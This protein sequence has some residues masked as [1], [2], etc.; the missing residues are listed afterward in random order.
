MGVPFLP[1]AGSTA[2][3]WSA[4]ADAVPRYGGGYTQKPKEVTQ[5]TISRKGCPPKTDAGADADAF[6]GVADPLTGGGFFATRN[7]GQPHQGGGHGNSQQ[8]RRQVHISGEQCGHAD[9]QPDGPSGRR[10]QPGQA[11]RVGRFAPTIHRSRR[12]CHDRGFT[13]SAR[14][15]NPQL[16]GGGATLPECAAS[17]RSSAARTLRCV[18]TSQTAPAIPLTI[19]RIGAPAPP[20]ACP[21]ANPIRPTTSATTAT[22]TPATPGMLAPYFND[23]PACWRVVRS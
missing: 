14:Q 10:H 1:N 20:P 11:E 8:R 23:S 18:G 13:R 7:P 22:A 12:S 4:V 3:L 16:V 5:T 21:V 17:Q 9:D 15:S 2:D 19:P 6:G